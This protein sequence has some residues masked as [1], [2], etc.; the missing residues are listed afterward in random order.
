MLKKVILAIA[1]IGVS[2][3]ALAHDG[4]GYE[5]ERDRREHRFERFHEERRPIIVEEARPVVVEPAPRMTYAPPAV[6]YPQPAWGIDI[7]LPL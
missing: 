3:A 4:H 2:S 6:V 1:A 5:R 7:R